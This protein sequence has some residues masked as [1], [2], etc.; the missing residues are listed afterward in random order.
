MCCR[1]QSPGQKAAIAAEAAAAEG[2]KAEEGDESKTAPRSGS[3][4]HG[5]RFREWMAV[6]AEMHGGGG[7][8]DDA[9]DGN[10]LV[11]KTEDAAFYEPMGEWMFKRG[12]KWQYVC[13]GG[14]GGGIAEASVCS[15]MKAVTHVLPS[16]SFAR[17]LHVACPTP[18]R[19]AA[20]GT[21]CGCAVGSRRVVRGAGAD[22]V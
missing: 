5:P 21:R 8:D 7:D 17:C 11:I 15:T 14:G 19:V 12:H 10:D 22:A 2:G 18:S 16:R 1:F 9:A 3:V 13:S 6:A 4:H 20:P